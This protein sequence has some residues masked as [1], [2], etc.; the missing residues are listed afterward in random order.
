MWVE[1]HD[2]EVAADKQVKHNT[3]WT[4]E[5][6]RYRFVFLRYRSF[7]KARQIK[8]RDPCIIRARYELITLFLYGFSSKIAAIG[9]E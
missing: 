6:N 1:P 4:G 2:N 9:W 5:E 7:V 8:G 3:A